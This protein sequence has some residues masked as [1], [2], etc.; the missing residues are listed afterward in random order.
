MFGKQTFGIEKTL[1][2][3]IRKIARILLMDAPLIQLHESTFLVQIRQESL[4]KKMV[5]LSSDGYIAREQT[6]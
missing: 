6:C 5:M 2:P 3:H 4:W 1:P